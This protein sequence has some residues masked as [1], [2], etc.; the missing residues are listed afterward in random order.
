M[1]RGSIVVQAVLAYSL[2]ALLPAPAGAQAV[3]QA[4]EAERAGRTQEAR[5]V[6]ARAAADTSSNAETQLAYAEFLERYN[7]PNALAIY[8]AALRAAPSNE[9]KQRIAKRLAVVALKAGD[10]PTAEAAVAAYQQAGGAG[11]EQAANRIG[12][13]VNLETSDF[14]T[15]QIPGILD[16]FLRMAG[17]ST[18]LT[19]EQLLPALAK[20]IITRGYRI[21][22]DSQNATE[23]LKLIQQYLSQARELRQFAGEDNSLDVPGCESVETAEILKILGYRLRGECG[24]EAVL[25]TVNPSRAFLSIDSAFPLSE[26]EDAY[27]RDA[28]FHWPYGATTIPVLFGPDYWTA[29]A[30]PGTEGEFIDVFLADPALARLYS[31]LSKMHRSTAN[32]L[33]QA[34]PV[35]TLKNYAP[36]LDFFGESFE[37]RGGKAITPGGA[38]ARSKWGDLAGASPDKGVEFFAALIQ[39]DDGWMAAYFDAMTRVSGPAEA[40]LSDP[41]RMDRFYEALR[42]Q[43][44]SPGPARP[45]FR[46][47]AD[48]LLLTTRMTFDANGQAHIPGTVTAWKNLFEKHPHGKYDGKLTRSAANW[49]EPDDVVEAL[50]A[51]SRKVVEN[52][53]LEIFLAITNLERARS[54]PFAPATVER[55]IL[56]YPKFG[57]QF[58]FLSEVPEL[59]DQTVIAFLDSL[60]ELDKND[61]YGRRSDI[62]GSQ[63]ALVSLWQILVRQGH[64]SPQEADK[65]LYDISVSFREV[66][67]NDDALFQATRTGVQRLLAA[68]NVQTSAD[69]HVALV[70]L[71]S[72]RPGP[73]EASQH[74]A[75]VER[76]N[77]LFNQQRLVSLKTLFDLADHLE[78]VS[79]GESFNVAMANRL[80]ETISDVRLPQSELSTPEAN[81][82]GLDNWVDRHIREQRELNLQRLVDRAAGDLGQML[83]IR[84]TIAPILRDS[85]VGL[86]YVYYSPPGAELIRSNPLFVRS[87]DFA[88]S[89]GRHSWETPRDRGIGWP[90]SAGGRLIGSLAGLPYTLNDAEQNFL[91]PSE[92]QALIWQDLA[93]QVLLGATVPRWW[94]VSRSEL[95]YIGLHLRMGEALVAESK[96]DP[97][98]QGQVLEVLR[99]KV[100]PSRLWLLESRLTAGETASALEVLTPAEYFDLASAFAGG[101]SPYGDPF[102]SEIR[103]LRGDTPE[104]F[105][106]QRISSTFGIPHPALSESYR[107]ELLRLPL[108]P[109]MMGYSSRALAESW[110]STNLY[111]AALADESHLEPADLNLRVPEWT[112]QSIERIFA[113]HLEDWPA[114]MRSMRIVGDRYREQA[115]RANAAA[116]GRTLV[117]QAQEGVEP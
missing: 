88:G 99:Q 28:A 35:A 68:A 41:R 30:T 49:K 12:A 76:F 4:L 42:G 51:L 3:T 107:P 67:R 83:E 59:S 91:I 84:G 57:R 34:L 78:R 70:R 64:I 47:T 37:I 92:R 27:R 26:L 24:P 100:S 5:D 40:Y 79:R 90:A 103:R 97:Q 14:G 101:D 114:L 52:E 36:V 2:T 87:H 31:T 15:T 9:L 61:N 16:G 98:L 109:T 65:S 94:D 10:Q 63:Q 32:E 58:S 6:L 55:L 8:Q 77:S 106:A 38:R 19:S 105:S 44:T 81:A 74:E 23:Y 54:Q 1:S 50:F 17:L 111:W 116:E 22:M 18:D 113:T 21:S 43:V 45:I 48:L 108:F 69:P 110:E 86:V 96:L 89:E 13:G 33:R 7:D 39:Q 53:P 60:A 117:G 20:N 72:G 75:L 82:I 115:Q 71:L 73:G 85:L 62:V 112:Q 46:A 95:H 93:P 11:W 29:A 80:A 56:D 25:E 102:V 104:R 66:R